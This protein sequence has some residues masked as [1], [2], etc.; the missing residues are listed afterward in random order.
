MKQQFII[1][2]WKS[3]KTTK[4]AIDWLMQFK[5]QDFMVDS[6]KTIIV[7][8][9]Y[10]L[11][12]AMKA[13]IAEHSMGITLGA[14][15][16]SP[17]DPGPYTG[18]VNGFQIKEFAE[19]VIIGHSERRD[20]F[21]ESEEL[22]EKKVKAA[23]KA[24]LKSIF[25][26]QNENTQIPDGAT[27]VAYEPPGSISTVSKGVPDNPKDVEVVVKRIKETIVITPIIYGV[28]VNPENV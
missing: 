9:S 28:S 8:A 18:E 7:C 27:I 21:H 25:C 24:G 13:F 17:F 23:Q 10:T 12:P 26:V 22:L 5:N 2:N 20:N 15:D 4:E 11:L 3:N 14:Q 1:G 19:Y 6:G 16:I